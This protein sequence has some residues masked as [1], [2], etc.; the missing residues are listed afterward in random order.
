MS[1]NQCLKNRLSWCFASIFVVFSCLLPLAVG[2][3][4]LFFEPETQKLGV[5]QEFR[6]DLMIDPQGEEI[7][8]MEAT[9]IF[10]E[11][12][13]EV[14]NIED[15]GSILTLWIERPSVLHETD[16]KIKF[17][18]IIPG[19]FKGIM[20][21]FKGTL[22]GKILSLIIVTTKEGMGEVVLKNVQVLLHDGKGTST[23]S[24]ISNFK[25]LIS[26]QIPI[27]QIPIPEIDDVPPELFVPEIARD[28]DMFGKK[29]F[30]VFETQDKISGIDYYAIHE[31]TQKKEAKQIYTK[32]W[33]ET[34]SPYI[35]KDQELRSYIYVKAVDKA[36][37][38]RLVEV[39][40]KYPIKWYENYENWFIIIIMLVII[41][42]I[43]RRFSWRNIT[44][45]A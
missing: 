20:G 21:P 18:G 6:V 41:T 37:N 22:P 11:D 3:V 16:T 1:T 35:L 14:I 12:I 24:K 4:E 33:I 26:K 17:S 9:I 30:L 19:G 10:P 27:T 5:G 38:E 32:D 15:G 25:F 44:K 40:P 23:K 39:M 7:N 34:E 29:W 28:P 8:A 42:Y 45:Q 31:T 43:I 2:A 36:G 13:I